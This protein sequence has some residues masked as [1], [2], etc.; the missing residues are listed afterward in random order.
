MANLIEYLFI[1]IFVFKYRPVA[2][3]TVGHQSFKVVIFQDSVYVL[4]APPLTVV[5]DRYKLWCMIGRGLRD[6]IVGLALWL[7][8]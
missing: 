8:A 1:L 2:A 4:C 3:V 6:Y 5:I 7:G